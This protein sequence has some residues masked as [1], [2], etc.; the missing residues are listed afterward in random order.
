[1]KY[2]RKPPRPRD[3]NISYHENQ[4]SLE[5]IRVIDRLPGPQGWAS[6]ANREGFIEA[7]YH[8][9]DLEEH[10]KDPSWTWEHARLIYKAIAREFD[11]DFGW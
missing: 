10:D 4:F 5:D 1:V 2:P 8:L 7:L 9:L 3:G 6:E 11:E